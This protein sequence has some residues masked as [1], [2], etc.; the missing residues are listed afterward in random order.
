MTHILHFIHGLNIGGAESFIG[1]I[2]EACDTNKFKFGFA[3]Q[4]PNITNKH[5]KSLIQSRGIKIH[6]I[7][8]F[9]FH[10]KG[11]YE[12]LRRVI[13]D[14]H[15]D[16]IHIHA[17]SLVNPIPLIVSDHIQGLKTLMHSHNSSVRQGGLFSWMLHNVNRHLFINKKISLIACSEKAARWM[18]GNKEYTFIPNALNISNYIFSNKGRARIRKRYF[19]NNDDIVLGSIGRLVYAK[20]HKFMLDIFKLFNNQ[21]PKSKLMIVG[22]GSLKESLM[23]YADKLGVIKNVIFAGSQT[24]TRDFYS[25]MDCFLLTSHYEGLPFTAIEAQANGLPVVA[26]NNI[27]K[28]MQLTDFVQFTPP[29]THL[30]K[31][32]TNRTQSML[33]EEECIIWIDSIN[34]LLPL[35]QLTEKTIT[36]NPLFGSC[37][38][39]K[40]Q[41]TDI[42]DIYSS[43]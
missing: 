13:L 3:L 25:S 42:E 11:Q 6:F 38:D 5:L 29:D 40:K 14:N 30:Y 31:G 34:K 2:I 4:N 35:R 33:N 19:I 26:S 27:T 32:E 21:Y 7:P 17:N 9:P 36:D 20:N 43:D 37:F 12:E 15:Y 10:L 16:V 8:R 41:I 24:E 39:I 28:E 18:F 1:N 22:D 23:K